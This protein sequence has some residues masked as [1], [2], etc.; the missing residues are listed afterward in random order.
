MIYQARIEANIGQMLATW[1]G[2]DH[3]QLFLGDDPTPYK[4]IDVFNYG[5]DKSFL[6]EDAISLCDYMLGLIQDNEPGVKIVTVEAVT[7][8]SE[9]V[10]KLYEDLNK[11]EL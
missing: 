3:I 8:S 9:V 11:E 6:A 10:E 1:N 2:R 5:E 7:Y 4:Y